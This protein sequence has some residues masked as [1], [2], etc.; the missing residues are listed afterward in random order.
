MEQTLCD[1]LAAFFREHEGEWIDGMRLSSIAGSYAWRSRCSDLRKPP[2]LMRIDNRMRRIENTA[3]AGRQV[4]M[5]E[6][7]YTREA[8]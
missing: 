5:S 7:R 2:F 6:Y 1:V 3:Y 8:D 4:T